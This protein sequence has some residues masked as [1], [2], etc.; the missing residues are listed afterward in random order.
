MK[1]KNLVE[2]YKE[3]QNNRRHYVDRAWETAKFFT[4]LHTGILAITVT[5]VLT[6]FKSINGW[7]ILFIFLPFME[8]FII[9]IGRKNFKR[10]YAR[11][12]Q[13][14]A[15][16]VK[17]EKMLSFH[18]RVS[19]TDRKFSDDNYVLPTDFV[20]I[21]K[22][23]KLKTTKDF[24]D[25]MF[26]KESEGEYG[27]FYFLFDKLFILYTIISGVIFLLIIFLALLAC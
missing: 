16:L 12:N 15:T 7:I 22:S 13:I 17:I 10:E 4:T 19:L 27:K 8:I 5:L 20:E 3:M 26:E 2:L 25:Y 18:D 14:I 24:V 11:L 9:H 6:F 23:G 1:E 21:N